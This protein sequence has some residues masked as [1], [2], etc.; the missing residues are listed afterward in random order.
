[1]VLDRALGLGALL[2]A[3][4]I[5][6]AASRWGIGTLRLPGPGFWPLLIAA[7]VAGLGAALL[8]RPGLPAPP[9]PAAGSR[10]ASLAVAL[11][12][13]G[14]FVLALEPLGYPVTVALLLLAQLRAV[15]GRGWRGSMLTAVLAAVISF[16]LFRAFL[17]VPLPAGILP[18]PPGW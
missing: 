11:A 15:E 16:V 12:T 14:F 9:A 3:I 8:L 4:P 10:W 7:A 2:L 1:M 18:L 17:K 6:L 5:A 13:L